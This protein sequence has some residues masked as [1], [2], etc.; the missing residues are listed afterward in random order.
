MRDRFTRIILTGLAAGVIS[1][2]LS[3]LLTSLGVSRASV[4]QAGASI[5]LDPWSPQTAGFWLIGLASHFAFSALYGLAFL[6]F[7]RVFG[8]DSLLVKGLAVGAFAWLAAGIVTRLLSLEPAMLEDT[9]TSL[10]WL[11]EHLVYGT[12]L[13]FFSLFFERKAAMR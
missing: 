13:A 10:A 3:L 11:A 12:A 2:A 4:I 6:G 1:G 8:D 9:P 5:F 7:R